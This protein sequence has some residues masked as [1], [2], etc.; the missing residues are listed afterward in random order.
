M[1]IHLVWM[2]SG[3]FWLIQ[4]RNRRSLLAVM[5]SLAISCTFGF[6][7][8]FPLATII[9]VPFMHILIPAMPINGWSIFMPL[10]AG[11]LMTI[12]EFCRRALR[13]KGTPFC[14]HS[15]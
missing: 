1:N 13:R 11:I 14:R 15:V 7:D 10:A 9:F 4:H 12:Y 6:I 5:V 3:I 8:L 2:H